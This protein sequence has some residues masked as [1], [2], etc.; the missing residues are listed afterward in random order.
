[1][2]VL[3]WY[4]TRED[5]K[6]AT[7]VLETAR[8]NRQV[9]RAI[10]AA[11]RSVENLC[12]R[13]F[14]PTVATRY[15]DWPS[16]RTPTSWRLW[17]EPDEIISLTSL[18]SG[19][20]TIASSDYN[21]EPAND[22]PPYDRIEIDLA[23]SASFISG[24][25][26]Q[27]DIAATGVFG[28]DDNTS[29]AGN[30]SAA[31][32]STSATSC[33]VTDSSVIGVGSL[34]TVGSEKM[35]VMGKSQVDT[36]QNIGGDLTASAAGTSVIVTTGSAYSVDEVITVDSERMRIVDITGNLL[37]VRRAWDGST[38]ATHMTGADIYAPR[39]LTV[40][41]GALGTTAATHLISASVSAQLYPGPVVSLTLAE[42]LNTLAQEGSGYA[43]TVG[44]GEASRN[45]SGSALRELRRDVRNGPLGRMVGPEAV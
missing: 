34:L 36:A 15:F 20:E 38:L 28:Y 41:R 31:I 17:T 1:M 6:S 10:E 33:S 5:V 42:A 37:T 30:L 26:P 35:I 4:V 8:S 16:L 39:T 3:P 29:P 7:D 43:R 21:L 9:D 45:A 32:V 2:G 11:S 22:G 24:D 13:K 27:R 19:G 25:T 23:S 12:R 18:V 40:A 44:S 14:Y